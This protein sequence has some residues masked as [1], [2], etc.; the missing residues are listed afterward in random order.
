VAAGEGRSY[1]RK[2]FMAFTV[3]SSWATD[4]L[5][6]VINCDVVRWP[7]AC[8][9]RKERWYDGEGRAAMSPVTG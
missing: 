8:H 3:V 2:Q 1:W 4:G 7:T 9:D 6:N 5:C